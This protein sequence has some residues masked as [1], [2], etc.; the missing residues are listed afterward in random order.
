MTLEE[1]VSNCAQYA[2]DEIPSDATSGEASEELARSI[3]VMESINPPPEVADYHNKTL[4]Y[5][6]AL[7]RLLDAQPEDEQPNLL[8]FLVL[9]PQGLALEDAMNDLDP[10]VRRR[11][12]AVGCASEGEAPELDRPEN[13]R[14]AVEGSTIRVSWD[15]VDGAGYYDVYFGDQ[16]NCRV[17]S[18]GGALSCEQLASDV[19][20][21]TYV[22]TDPHPDQNYYWVAAC[23]SLGCSGISAAGSSDEGPDPPGDPHYSRD[24]ATALVSWDPS[25]EATHY[26]IYYNQFEDPD[27]FLS[28]SGGPLGCRE[29]EGHVVGTTYIHERPD[30]D[31][32]YYWVVACNAGGCSEIDSTNPARPVATR[33]DTPSN[34]RFSVEGSTLRVSW[35]AVDE[36]DH[37]AVFYDDFFDSSC[38]LDRDIDSRFCDELATD[39]VETTYVHSSPGAGIN[40]YWV[41][42]CNRGG[43]SEVDSDNPARQG[44]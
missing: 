4:A 6:K 12:V 1:Y 27:C 44:R 36:A 19:V 21:T 15:Q 30:P 25:E 33:P 37:Y 3:E 23:D 17:W 31:L 8:A 7:K 22:H 26:K 39:L 24:R 28:G 18:G 34:V 32:N 2:D 11:L 38:S 5:G 40:Y 14:F 20:E 43:C 9:A 16:P 41:I 10:E 35:D 42:A 29:L 13:V